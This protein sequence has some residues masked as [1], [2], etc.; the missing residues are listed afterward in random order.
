MLG[1]GCSRM[2]RINS[3]FWMYTN[4]R[5]KPNFSIRFNFNMQPNF[6]IRFDF[7]MQPNFRTRLDCSIK[8]NFRIRFDFSI[9]P[10]LEKRLS[11]Q[12]HSRQWDEE[13]SG[14]VYHQHPM[15][16][17]V[18]LMASVNN[19]CPLSIIH[20]NLMESNRKQNRFLKRGPQFNCKFWLINWSH[21]ISKT[22][23]ISK[24][25]Q[26]F[27]KNIAQEFSV[28]MISFIWIY[29]LVWIFSCTWIK[30]RHSMWQ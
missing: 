4:F 23:K 13:V 7:S 6:R 21:V 18:N 28:S 30:F 20:V 25:A 10:V 2:W 27:P 16:H 17:I 15:L 1:F 8:P 9:K 24:N 12:L 5:M 11:I 19:G 29:S 26:N 3:K 14:Q 22:L